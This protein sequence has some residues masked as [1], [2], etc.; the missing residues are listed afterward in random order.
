MITFVVH[1][2]SSRT[3]P[4]SQHKVFPIFHSPEK[5]A[6]LINNHNF[7]RLLL[8]TLFSFC[9]R[10]T[11]IHFFPWL[12][13]MIFSKKNAE[14]G[15]LLV[16]QCLS[17]KRGCHSPVCAQNSAQWMCVTARPWWVSCVMEGRIRGDRPEG[18][19]HT[20]FL[21][22]LVKRIYCILINPSFIHLELSP[23]QPDI[24]FPKMGFQTVEGSFSSIQKPLY[25]WKPHLWN[26]A[27]IDNHSQTR[28]CVTDLNARIILSITRHDQFFKLFLRM[29]E[30]SILPLF[31][32]NINCFKRSL[33]FFLKITHCH[34][35]KYFT[36]HTNWMVF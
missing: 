31:L 24:C 12:L 33:T 11:W 17:G 13:Y 18:S 3:Q 4:L 20:R 21:R 2:D 5:V 7:Q 30:I 19:R 9:H 22:E 14:G 15:F 26:S 25:S 36:A 34:T 35:L 29:T 8:I 27:H 32:K 23:W 6:Q 1:W 28:V 16:W 10:E